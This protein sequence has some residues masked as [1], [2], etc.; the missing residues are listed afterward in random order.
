MGVAVK[1]AAK[2]YRNSRKL[3]SLLMDVVMIYFYSKRFRFAPSF[4]NFEKVPF[5]QHFIK[6]FKQQYCHVELFKFSDKRVKQSRL[7]EHYQPV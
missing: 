3:S 4:N 5:V 1:S 2:I 6:K 7:S